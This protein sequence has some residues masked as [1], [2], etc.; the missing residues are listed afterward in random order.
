[1]GIQDFAREKKG[2]CTVG[3]KKNKGPMRE[4]DSPMNREC[5]IGSRARPLSLRNVD[6]A[7]SVSAFILLE[8]SGSAARLGPT[9]T[10]VFGRPGDG[11][12]LAQDSLELLLFKGGL[13]WWDEGTLREGTQ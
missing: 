3:K 13:I 4:E 10:S 11:S 2:F 5:R 8:I 6:N 12:Y 7:W 1:M 9:V